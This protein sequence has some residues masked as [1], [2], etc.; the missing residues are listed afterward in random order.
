M[1]AALKM[2]Y[3]YEHSK[4]TTIMRKIR[5]VCFVSFSRESYFPYFILYICY[6]NYFMQSVSDIFN[7]ISISFFYP[8][9]FCSIGLCCLYFQTFIS[10]FHSF[11]IGKRFH[12]N[13]TKNYCVLA[14]RESFWNNKKNDI[15]KAI[16]RLLG[17]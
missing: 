11:H 9:F 17:N 13:T 15:P 7:F 3:L 10:K 6:K 12:T 2:T 8:I 4:N 14:K 1:R 16:W 5:K